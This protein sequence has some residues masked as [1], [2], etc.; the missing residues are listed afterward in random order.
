MVDVALL[1]GISSRKGEVNLLRKRLVTVGLPRGAKEVTGLLVEETEVGLEA[2]EL[3]PTE[4]AVS[5][6]IKLCS[7]TVVSQRSRII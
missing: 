1:R 6:L 5:S 2:T 3:R 4:D 7:S